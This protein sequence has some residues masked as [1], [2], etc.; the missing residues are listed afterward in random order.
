MR[1]GLKSTA[2][3]GVLLL[4][5]LTSCGNSKSVTSSALANNNVS[6]KQLIKTINATKTDFESLVGKLKIETIQGDKSQSFSLS[7]RWEKDQAIWISKFGIV[8][9]LI[10][11]SR[12]AFYNKL[13]QTYFDGDFTYLSKIVGTE[14][15][16]NK[17][18]HILLGETIFD[19]DEKS[20]R[21]LV[22]D[23]SYVLM[24]K[25]QNAL[26]EIFFLMHPKH[27]KANSQQITQEKEKRILQI[28][29]LDYQNV[30]KIIVPQNIKVIA[31]EA[32]SEI[33]INLELKSLDLNRKLKFPFKIPSG[34][35][36]I[37]L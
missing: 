13:D 29:Y 21:S 31:V 7:L 11:P 28:D 17:L 15:D 25:T 23:N 3:I 19:L 34:L 24:P 37:K 1:S 33:Q 26:F 36:E 2:Y 4:L 27:F 8:K 35:A 6:T 10:T 12:V 18:Q 9:A 14:L 32:E 5:L 16:F 20:Y 30:E 22:A